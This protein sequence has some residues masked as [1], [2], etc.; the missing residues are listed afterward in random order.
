MS[1]IPGWFPVGVVRRAP[2]LVPVL[3]FD[4]LLINDSNITNYP[5]GDAN[6]GAPA[7]GRRVFAAIHALSGFT[8][9]TITSVTIGGITAT[10]HTQGDD[11]TG[12][13]Y[14]IGIASAIVPTGTTAAVVVNFSGAMAVCGVGVWYANNLRDASPLAASSGTNQPS[15]TATLSLSLDAEQNCICIFTGGDTNGVWTASAPLTTRFD[16]PIEVQQI[17][18]GADF[19]SYSGSPDPATPTVTIQLAAIAVYA[20]LTWR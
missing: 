11:G 16:S 18:G 4:Q 14:Y 20:G 8:G 13:G 19:S 2:A 10:I 1:A 6:I 3:T 12:A 9:R 15:G 7:A 5:M 17:Q